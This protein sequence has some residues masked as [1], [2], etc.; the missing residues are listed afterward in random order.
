MMLVKRLRPE[1]SLPARGS[2]LAAGFDLASAEAVTVPKAGK[3]IVKTG[4]SLAVPKGTYA[5]LAPRSGLAAKKMIDVG[6]GVVD[7]DYRG[8][9][10]VV[11]FN[12]GHEDFV[13]EAGDRI[14]QLVVEKVTM[15]GCKEV[16]SLDQT[17]RG[18][19][20]FGSTGVSVAKAAEVSEVPETKKQRLEDSWFLVKKLRPEAT[21]PAK[22]SEEAA[23]FDLSAAEDTTVPPGGKAIIK[24]GLSIAVP[25]GTYGRI[26]PRSGL[27]AKNMIHC[28]AGVVDYD[29]RGEVGVVLFNYGPT[30][31]V[32]AR[33]D[34]VAQMILE[35]VSMVGTTEVD[36]L[37]DTARG[38]SGFGSTGISGDTVATS[39]KNDALR[40]CDCFD[41][42]LLV[43]KLVPL[44][45]MPA[46]GSEHAAGFD[47][48]AVE[49]ASVPA[50]GKSIVK[51]GLSVATPVG[52]YGRIAPRSGLAA[53]RM[54]HV[55]AGVVDTDY[56]GEVGVVLFNHGS[57]DFKIFPGDRIAQ[58]ILEK[59]AMLDC[60]EVESLEDTAR[61]VG[62]FGSTGVAEKVETSMPATP[63]AQATELA[64]A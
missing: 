62:G 37:D 60:K 36:V 16:E 11:L 2:S 64:G 25:E 6:A 58:F 48:A 47:L 49:E 40:S 42:S 63:L 35:K 38:S 55:L 32:V 50:G 30:E 24:T 23:G 20:G 44:A 45:T 46:R 5:R 4:L 53:K 3:A 41:S 34:R 9:V 31:L 22:G 39:P 29:Y 52:T 7:S 8:E 21:L 12:H 59:I 19:G 13:V 1:A 18:S 56:R 17:A 10:G 43:K 28:G 26:A 27:A 51:T 57:E 33:G 14:A 54:I 61:G 15:C